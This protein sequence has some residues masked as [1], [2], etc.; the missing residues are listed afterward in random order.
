[1]WRSTQ[2]RRWENSLC[3]FT[4]EPEGWT[5]G[6]NHKVF[7]LVTRWKR[8]T[9]NIRM[10]RLSKPLLEFIAVKRD[11]TGTYWSIP[12]ISKPLYDANRHEM[13][14]GTA[15]S[16]LFGGPFLEVFSAPYRPL[17]AV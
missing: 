7:H 2:I 15:T 8:D 4:A 6:A 11:A 1:M 3:A 16:T 10:D 17:R 9:N 12:E 14:M 13:M 5:L